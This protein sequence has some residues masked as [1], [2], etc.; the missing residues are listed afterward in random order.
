MEPKPLFRFKTKATGAGPFRAGAGPPAISR[1]SKFRLT[2]GSLALGFAAA[3]LTTQVSADETNAWPAYVRR[4]SPAEPAPTWS[5]LGPFLFSRP[6]PD[7]GRTSGFRPFYVHRTD[8][9]GETAENT[10]L[11]PLFYY[12]RYGTTYEWSVFKLINRVGRAGDAPP[13][14]KAEMPESEKTFAIWPFYFSRK[15]H[16]PGES[17]RGLLPLYG[18]VQGILGY[19]R[20][21]WV[22]FPLY[23]KTEKKGSTTTMTPWPIIRV[24]R[25]YENGFAVWP[26]YGHRE[27]PDGESRTFVLWPLG[28]KNTI[29]P[30]PDAPPGTEPS[31]EFGALPFYMSDREPGLTNINYAWPFFGYTD[32]TEPNRYH[33]TRYFWPFLVQGHGDNG[34]VVNRWGP[35]Y[36]HSVDRGEDNTWILWPFWHRRTWTEGD[37]AM[38]KK[39]LL[40]FFYFS[41]EQHS[42]SRPRAAPAVKRHVF[43]V[44]SYWDNGAGLGQFQLASP[45]EAIFAD[46][47]QVR[48][49]WAPFFAVVRHDRTAPGVER[50]SLLWD[51]I[52]WRR[53]DNGRLAELHIGPIFALKSSEDGRLRA[54]WFNFAAGGR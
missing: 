15:S 26:I 33:E 16:D 20:I 18:D 36:T 21:S 5:A 54:S 13:A 34:R 23:V 11:Y 31:H 41:L 27:S 28:W 35:F 29:P 30:G 8:P 32:R 40:Y 12:R 9:H 47:P 14:E 17:Y 24:T 37:A 10:V 42:V 43:P 4:S 49:A 51:A 44:A 2:R 45:F 22:L 53:S 46:N 50:T 48:D 6:N 38:T 19:S 1:S 7:G 3:I 39:Q 52:T 25:G